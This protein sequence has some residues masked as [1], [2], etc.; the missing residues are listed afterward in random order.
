MVDVFPSPHFEPCKIL[1]FLNLCSP[2]HGFC[3]AKERDPSL[4]LELQQLGRDS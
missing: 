2:S 1:F 4:L 3:S